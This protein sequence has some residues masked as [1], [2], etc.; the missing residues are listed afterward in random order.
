MESPDEL[1]PSFLEEELQDTICVEKVTEVRLVIVRWSGTGST[2]RRILH[3]LVLI[4]IVR[5]RNLCT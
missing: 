3:P 1:T 2:A 4:S 5:R